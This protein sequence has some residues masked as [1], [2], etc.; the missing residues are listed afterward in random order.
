MGTSK[1]KDEFL[2]VINNSPGPAQINFKSTLNDAVSYRFL[3][4]D[5]LKPIKSSTPGP[6]EYDV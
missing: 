6:G 4:D 2:N 5:K 1:R 3:K